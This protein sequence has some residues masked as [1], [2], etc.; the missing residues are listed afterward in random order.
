MKKLVVLVLALVA[1]VAVGAVTVASAKPKPVVKVNTTIKNLAFTGS[2]SGG[3]YNPSVPG[4]Y[5]PVVFNG[6]FSGK[7]KAA[8]RCKKHRKIKITGPSGLLGKTNSAGSGAFDLSFTNS[9]GVTPGEYT[10][11]VKK[12]TINRKKQTII[13]KKTAKSITL[14]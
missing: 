2:F 8:K 10:V 11:K 14:G 13:C 3:T 12:K 6:K 9:T 4:Y 5:T 1:C 7:L